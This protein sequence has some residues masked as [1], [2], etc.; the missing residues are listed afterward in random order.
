MEEKRRLAKLKGRR[1]LTSYRITFFIFLFLIFVIGVQTA[2]TI[3][4]E[5]D[6]MINAKI[7]E[8]VA[9]AELTAISV[10]AAEVYIPVYK[11]NIVN[12][13]SEP[14]DIIYCRIVKP[15][16][17]IYI[18]NIEQ[19]RGKFIE[20]PA[21]ATSETVVK[22]DV[23]NGESI[24][25]V[26]TPSSRGYTIW[27]GFSLESVN[28]AVWEMIRDSMVI[29]GCVIA[30]VFLVYFGLTSI[31][32]EVSKANKELRD[33]QEQ[34]IQTEKLAALG[35]LSADIAHEINNPIGGIKN[36]L[37]LLSDSVSENK[38][39]YLEIAEKEVNRIATIVQRLLDLYRPKKE[40]MTL[41]NVNAPLDEILAVMKNQIAN[42]NVKIISDF[43]PKLPDVMA[44]SEHL[45]QVFLNIILNAVE[46]MPEGGELAIKTY[47]QMEHTG[48]PEIKIE[49]A[50]TGCGIPEEGI[51]KIFD[52]FFTTK[53]GGKG[54]G[55]GL[56][57]SYGVIQRHNGR[58]EVK[59]E[60]GKGT[61]FIIS[62]PM[63]EKKEGENEREEENT[64]S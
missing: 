6:Y 36:C 8:K 23:Y 15:T 14:E 17:Q 45:K 44:S 61:T 2:L 49:F 55:L 62:L 60:V 43:D 12:E 41:T 11:I 46:S 26:I 18:S 54:T 33:T 3:D 9:L 50:D 4:R 64:H 28:S 25:V 57:I 29:A 21:I 32:R 24:K 34:L 31:N 38:K 5:R 37:Y 20:D 7:S 39:E 19:E 47:S 35:R 48:E 22:D 30:M 40:I 51:D 10:G 56:S 1:R 52:P 16:G 42:R 13:V 27:V 53:K 63:H 58:I 59:S